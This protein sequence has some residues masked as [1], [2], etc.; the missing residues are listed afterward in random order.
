MPVI[1]RDVVLQGVDENGNPTIDLPVTR[2]GNIED[3][4]EV[5][6]APGEGDFLPIIDGADDGQMKKTPWVSMQGPP[7]PRGE[8]GERGP[9]GADGGPGPKGDPFTYE[10]FTEEQ[11]AVLRGPQGPAGEKGETGAQGPAGAAGE[12]GKS[13]YQYAQEGGYTG[14]EAEFGALLGLTGT[15]AAKLDEINGEIV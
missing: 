10:D 15:I 13:A 5:K 9:A 12:S 4:A 7:G 14:T 1:E 6:E 3:T 8:R 11:L 2:L